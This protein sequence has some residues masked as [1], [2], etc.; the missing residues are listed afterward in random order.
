MSTLRHAFPSECW[1]PVVTSRFCSLGSEALPPSHRERVRQGHERSKR[2]WSCASMNVHPKCFG[3]N[4]HG[5][6]EADV[7]NHYFRTFLPTDRSGRGKHFAGMERQSNDRGTHQQDSGA[8]TSA[9]I[10]RLIGTRLEDVCSRSPPL[11]NFCSR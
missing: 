9:R 3:G 6:H 11:Y 4:L 1:M 7:K 5:V 8:Y 2:E 10:S